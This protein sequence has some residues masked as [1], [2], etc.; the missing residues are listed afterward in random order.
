[1]AEN[2]LKDLIQDREPVHRRNLDISTYP[3]GEGR[4]VVEG[5]LKDERLVEIYR[6]WDN[7]PREAGVVHWFCAR[8]LVGDWPMTILD[9]EAEVRELPSDECVE[10]LDSIKRVVGLRI[11][12]GYSEEVRGLMGGAQ[13]CSHLTHL[14]IVM[15]PPALHG[16][17]TTFARHPRPMPTSLDEVEGLKY[18]VNSCA[19]WTPDGP[20]M[21]TLEEQIAKY[22]REQGLD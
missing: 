4:V 8:L 9:A 10:V 3:A 17:W 16:F 22:R 12:P 20:H 1:M 5:W 19:L 7:N 6:H 15:G 14:V 21:R 18:L 13:G 11:S 2:N